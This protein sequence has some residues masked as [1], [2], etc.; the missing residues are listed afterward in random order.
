[1]KKENNQWYAHFSSLIGDVKI[2]INLI[3][4][5]FWYRLFSLLTGEK[6]KEGVGKLPF[7]PSPYPLPLR[8]RS[9]R[10]APVKLT[11]NNKTFSNL[12][13]EDGREW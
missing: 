6:I 1:L 8:E 7:T 13:A 12:I 4:L 9:L 5:A 10:F 3:Q 2:T 11:L